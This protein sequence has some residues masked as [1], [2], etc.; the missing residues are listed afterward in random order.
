MEIENW[1]VIASKQSNNTKVYNEDV[2]PPSLQVAMK[3]E[4]PKLAEM[5]RNK[6]LKKRDDQGECGCRDGGAFHCVDYEL[7]ALVGALEVLQF[8]ELN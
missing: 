1:V 2:K 3:V 7:F 5:N 6:R 8:N 4:V